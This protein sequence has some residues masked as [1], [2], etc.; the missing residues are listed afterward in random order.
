LPYF[1]DIYTGVSTVLLG[2]WVTFKHLFEPTITVQYP[3]E[4]L[5]MHPRTRARLVN[6]IEEC[7]YC[8]SCQ[9]VCPAHLFTIKGVRRD[10]SLPEVILP[11]GKPKKIE[12][13]QFDIDM[14]KCLYCGLC[15]EACDTRSLRWEQPVEV[16]SHS[17][18][19]LFRE[20]AIY[21]KAERD[22]LLQKEEERKKA[23]AAARAASAPV[24][25]GAKVRKGKGEEMKE[26]K[27]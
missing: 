22:E 13:V 17:R 10:P 7:G 19:E 26:G 6:H 21:S 27:E 18:A 1:K 20:F 8:L 9:K 25:A 11:D 24:A 12:V 15:V 3:R 4:E 2:M 5:P 23:A 16:V 14:S